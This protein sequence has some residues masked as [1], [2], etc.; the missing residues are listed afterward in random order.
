[1]K[2]LAICPFCMKTVSVDNTAKVICPECGSQI[3]FH[4]FRRL[5]LFVDERTEAS[6]L[7]LAKS[8]FKNSDYFGA[9]EHF[10]KA[11]ES[12]KNSYAAQYFVALCDIYLHESDPEFDLMSNVITMIRDALITISRNN[13]SVDKKLEFITAMLNETK[14]IIMRKIEGREDLFESD[15]EQFRKV[16]IE[17]LGKLL[18]LFTIDRE[19]IMAFSDGV[20]QSLLQIAESAIKTTYRAVQTVI[21]GEDLHAPSDEVY[22]RL[23]SLC[24]DYCFFAHSLDPQFDTKNYSPDFSRNNMFTDKVFDRFDKFEQSN[25]LNPKKLTVGDIEEYDGIL[26]ECEKAL[27]FTYLNCYRSMC[28]RQTEQH[29]HLFID[30]IKLVSKLLLPRVVVTDKKTYDIRIGKFVEI[31]DWCDMLTRFLVDSYEL[32]DHVAQMQHDYYEQLLYILENY[33]VPETD[34]AAKALNKLNSQGAVDESS[35]YICRRYLFDVCVC[36]VPAL[37]KYVDF[38]TGRDKTREKIVKICKDAYENFILFAGMPTEEIEQ[39][40]IYRPLMQISN[41]LLDEDNE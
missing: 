13:T 4:E 2:I 22:K 39:S 32:S 9:S 11:L 7:K 15:I 17:D 21:V 18:E 25:K 28:S 3:G 35:R 16:S 8:A 33:I 14:I 26:A 36:C 37:K 40:N 20:K 12:N 19:L 5:K 38:S 1:M 29:A 24:N 10:A 27:K 23:L 34:K 41:A 30:G 6:E 31:V